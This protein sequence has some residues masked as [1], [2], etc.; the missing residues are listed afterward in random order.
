MEP[1]YDYLEINIFDIWQYERQCF[2]SSKTDQEHMQKL[3]SKIQ[4]KIYSHYFP[5]DCVAPGNIKF[6]IF[7][8]LQKN[9]ISN[10]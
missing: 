2:L 3:T 9:W 7:N 5:E 10:K 6:V 1:C 8:Q 4:N